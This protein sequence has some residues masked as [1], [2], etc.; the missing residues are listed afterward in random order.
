MTYNVFGGML[1]LAQSIGHVT[2]HDFSSRQH[3][4]YQTDS[5]SLWLKW[6]VVLQWVYYSLMHNIDEL[7]QHLFGVAHWRCNWWAVSASLSM[8]TLC[9]QKT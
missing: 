3:C 2:L 5:T 9:R 7:K 1:N 8:H 6:S 4:G